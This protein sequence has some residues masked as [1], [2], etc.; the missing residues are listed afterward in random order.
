MRQHVGRLL[1]LLCLASTALGAGCA[2]RSAAPPAA[3]AAEP[4]AASAAAGPTEPPRRSAIVAYPSP[5]L[6]Y[7]PLWVAWKEGLFAAEG[8][9]LDFT[10]LQSNLMISAMLAGEVDYGTSFSSIVR[11]AATGADVRAIL[12]TVDRPQHSFVLGPSVTSPEQLRGKRIGI[13]SLGGAQEY[14]AYEVL[15]RYGLGRSDTTMAALGSDTAR[16]Q[17]MQA[18]AI[19]A[20]VIGMPFDLVAED[21]GLRVL[22]RLADILA[23][24]HAGVG[25]STAKLRDAPDEVRRFL[26]ASLRGVDLTKGDKA[27]ALR[28]ME[29]WLDMT[30]E[31]ASRAYDA[32]VPTW[33]ETGI[34]PEAGLQLDLAE[35]KAQSGASEDI[36][37]SRVVDYTLLR[38]AAH[39]LER[40]VPP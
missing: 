11:A 26:R 34:A 33:S 5:S 39:D 4:A 40:P 2:A 31:M 14:E 35:V 29:D 37:V 1:A 7:F 24:T 38:E 32:A 15:A 17:A 30:P 10:Q 28:H 22:V 25:T 19:D 12:A 21:Q 18:G 3:T 6:S 16:L 23:L 8:L 20:A 13:N 27:V 9:D 36:P